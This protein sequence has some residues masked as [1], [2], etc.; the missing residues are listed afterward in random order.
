MKSMPV[1]IAL[2]YKHS[3]YDQ[4][5]RNT[6]AEK[7]LEDKDTSVRQVLPA[8]QE[9][10]STLE[11]VH[12]FLDKHRISYRTF[13]RNDIPDDFHADLWITVGGDGTFLTAA[14]Y[15]RQEPLFGINSSVHTSV[16]YFCS[17]DKHTFA[18]RLEEILA[19]P[20]SGVRIQ[21]QR[22]QLTLEQGGEQEVYPWPVLNDILVADACPAALSRYFFSWRG[23]TEFQRSSG[24][25]FSTAAGSGA[26]AASAGGRT[27]KPHSPLLQYIVRE[28]YRVGR[29]MRWL[30]HTFRK[31]EPVEIKSA[32]ADGRIFVDGTLDE[33]P[34][35]LGS[36]LTVE[37]S[38]Y[39]LLSY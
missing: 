15:S 2:V 3:V 8:H 16:G 12:A 18:S 25:W 19:N 27:L 14:R 28:P 34:F 22:M 39:P 38:P 23:H 13:H 7:L 33:I 35:G 1:E 10:N 29:S 20:G 36:N 30:R 31:D 17:A 9:H 26:A 32:M 24:I 11:Q 6:E 21:Y 37:I 5:I 4:V